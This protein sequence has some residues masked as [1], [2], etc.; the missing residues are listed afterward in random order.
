MDAKIKNKSASAYI[1]E[2]TISFINL[3]VMS[4]E[5][6]NECKPGEKKEDDVAERKHSISK[7]DEKSN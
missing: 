2:G 3:Q 4:P 7:I 6:T 5:V 1:V